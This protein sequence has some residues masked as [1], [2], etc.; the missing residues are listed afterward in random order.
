M[1]ALGVGQAAGRHSMWRRGPHVALGAVAICTAPP[2]M[3]ASV[4]VGLFWG[5]ACL[6]STGGGPGLQGLRRLQSLGGAGYARRGQ[7]LLPQGNGVVSDMSGS[8]RVWE[9]TV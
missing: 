8:T 3:E 1:E 4:G 2:Q 6:V 5:S 7:A 9:G